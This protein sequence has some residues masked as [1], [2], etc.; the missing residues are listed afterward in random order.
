MGES[1]RGFGLEVRRKSELN[2]LTKKT[3]TIKSEGF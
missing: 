1:R 3:E 2:F